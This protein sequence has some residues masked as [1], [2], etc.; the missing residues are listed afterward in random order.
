V[1]VSENRCDYDD[2]VRFSQLLSVPFLVALETQIFFMSWPNMLIS[3][4]PGDRDL[5]L[6]DHQ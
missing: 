4:T 3:K 1:F 5:V 6:M 2:A